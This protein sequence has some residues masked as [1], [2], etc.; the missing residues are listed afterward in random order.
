MPA[1]CLRSPGAEGDRRRDRTP[2]AADRA[3]HHA[4]ALAVRASHCCSA[5]WRS[6][7]TR[8]T[9]RSPNAGPPRSP[10]TPTLLNELLGRVELRELLE[11]GSSTPTER[12]LQRLAPDRKVRGAGRHRGP[13]APAGPAHAG[14]D[15]RPRWRPV[16]R[17]PAGGG[18]APR[19]TLP[20]WKRCRSERRERVSR[21]RRGAGAP[22][23]TTGAT[24]A[25]TAD[26]AAP[27]L[28]ELPAGQPRHQGRHRRRRTL[29]RGGG[30]RPAARC[31]RRP[32][33]D[34]RAAG[35]HRAGRRPA[36]RPRLAATPAPTGPSPPPRPPRRLGLGVAV[37]GTALKRLAADGRV[38]EGEF[39]PTPARRMRRRRRLATQLRPAENVP[40][41]AV[42][43]AG[44]SEWCD[45]EVLRKLR[46]RSLAALRGRGRTGGRRRL[47]PVPPGLAERRPRRRG[48]SALRGLD[49]IV[50]AVD[51]L[52]GVPIP[53]SA[54]EPLVLAGR[55]SDY[56]PAMLDELM[57]A[58]EVLWSGAGSLPGNDGWISL[59]LADSRRTDAES[60]SPTS[61]P[62]MRSSGLLDAPA[63]DNGGGYFFRQLTDVAGGMDSVLGDQDVVCRALGPGLGRPDHRRHVRPG[64]GPDRRRPHR[65]PAGRT[66][67]RGPGPR[68]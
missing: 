52:S 30:R 65:P 63:P 56:Q 47:R 26:G 24:A 36:R 49:G 40:P 29:G 4:A 35:L 22:P 23:S 44:V 1:G 31:P 68:G 62:A 11:R 59:H 28:A 45:A 48:Q 42:R 61:S 27:L 54:W 10:W 25:T 37:V 50:T 39:R 43:L 5:T 2:R 7:S 55:V 21:S 57:A 32:A 16:V 12:E 19:R 41:T 15:R 38:V 14:G 18:A 17:S 64:A 67:R 9:P 13:A 58:G 33:A 46:R 8:A 60:R 53:A 34:G 66:R 6:S 20:R 3:D 51:Q